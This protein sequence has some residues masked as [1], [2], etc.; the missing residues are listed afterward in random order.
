MLRNHK[1]FLVHADV[2]KQFPLLRIYVPVVQRKI[3]YFLDPI[4][5]I[6]YHFTTHFKNYYSL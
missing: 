1:I 4:H 2:D 3:Q 5:Q 6:F